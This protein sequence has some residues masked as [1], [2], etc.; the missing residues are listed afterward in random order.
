MIEYFTEEEYQK[1]KSTDFLPLKCEHCGEIFPCIKKQITFER[2]HKK[3]IYRYCS[4]ICQAKGGL[5]S[6]NLKCDYCGKI[7]TKKKSDLEKSKHHFCNSQCAA[8]YNN[9]HRT[10][11]FSRSKL[12]IY[13]EKK[14]K[15]LYSNLDFKF[16][17]RITIGS[18]LDILIPSLNLAFELNGI[19][20]YEPI[21]GEE[22]YNKIKIRD[23]NKFQMCLEHKISLCIID[24]SSQKY[25][26]ERSSQ[27][28]LNIIKEIIDEN[29]SIKNKIDNYIVEGGKFEFPKPHE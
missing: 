24:T 8:K 10:Y 2:K 22:T 6:F 26:N 14:L 3:G 27:K 20:H 25:F 16:N 13:L 11:G 19:F 4:R 29:L 9:T 28:F 1:A 23:K 7:I 18:E 15:E 5:K 17:D 21:Y 12:E